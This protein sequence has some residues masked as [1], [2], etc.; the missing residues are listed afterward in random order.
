MNDLTYCL[1]GLLPGAIRYGAEVAGLRRDPD[2]TWITT[3]REGNDLVASETVVLATGGREDTAET[4]ARYGI[5]PRRLIA[6]GALLGGSLEDAGLILRAGGRVTVLGGSHSG[7]AAAGLIL[8]RFGAYARP[9]T[10]AV[11]HRG[12]A[13]AY[14]GVDQIGPPHPTAHRPPEVCG[15]TGMVNRFHGLRGGPRALC[16]RALGGA[17]PRLRLHREGT[18]GARDAVA[19]AD[20]V[21]H[22]TGYR[23]EQVPTTGRFGEPIPLRARAGTVAVDD[24]CRVLIGDGG[25]LPGVYGLGL[26]YARSD[27]RGHSKVG[28]NLFHGT[29]ADRI[30]HAISAT[31]DEKRVKQ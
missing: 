30:I 8:D 19:G 7:F 13:F 2:G 1:E 6:S 5:D 28:I 31:I 14:A 23:T 25:V 11:V 4:A 24:S 20:L 3:D 21:V 9:G 10:L 16:E 15:E 12:L 17:E 18:A 26:G 29:D 27:E 22:A